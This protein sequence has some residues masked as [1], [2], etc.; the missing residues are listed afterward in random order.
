MKMSAGDLKCFDL[1]EMPTHMLNTA[2]MEQDC[3]AIHER[4]PDTRSGNLVRALSDTSKIG[5]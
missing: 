2:T 4:S 5:P 3:L 1:K